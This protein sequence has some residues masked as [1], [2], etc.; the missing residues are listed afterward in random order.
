MEITPHSGRWRTAKSFRALR[1]GCGGRAAQQH[2]GLDADFAQLL[3]GVL[4][5]LGLEFAGG[6]DPGDVAQVHEGGVVGAQ[7]QAHLAHGFQEGQR[8]DVADGAADFDDGDIDR[9]RGFITGAAFDEFLDLIGDVRD[10]LHGLAEVV[11]AALFFEHA[12]VD[13]AGGEVVGLAHARF[14]E[15]LIVA[16]VQVGFGAVVGHK[17]LAVLEG[18]HRAR[19]HVEV[20]IELD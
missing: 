20:G 2:I 10:D 15:T 1:W 18:R 7:A 19:I 12:F 5:R 13:L 11:A 14:D 8:F 3:G 6:G 4:G 9:V 16:Q 17:N